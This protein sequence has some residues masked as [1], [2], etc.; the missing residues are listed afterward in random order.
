MDYLT[1]GEPSFESNWNDKDTLPSHRDV[2]NFPRT[3]LFTWVGLFRR[4]EETKSYDTALH[5]ITSQNR[6]HACMTKSAVSARR[7]QILWARALPAFK[8]E[9]RL[10]SLSAPPKP[11]TQSM[12]PFL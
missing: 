9:S 1:A 12:V 10:P 6:M 4:T 5:I 8:L 11:P 3:R 7:R 2:V